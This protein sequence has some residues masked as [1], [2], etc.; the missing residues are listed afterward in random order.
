MQEHTYFRSIKQR[1]HGTRRTSDPSTGQKSEWD[2]SLGTDPPHGFEANTSKE[3]QYGDRA[4]L[5]TSH[6]RSGPNGTAYLS[7][8]KINTF[9]LQK[10]PWVWYPPCCCPGGHSCPSC[11]GHRWDSRGEGSSDRM[12]DGLQK[13]TPVLG[14]RTSATC[15]TMLSLLVNQATQLFLLI[16]SNDP[17]FLCS[18]D[19]STAHDG[20]VM[21]AAPSRPPAPC[22]CSY[23]LPSTA[24]RSDL[25]RVP[26]F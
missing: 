21:A 13:W 9:L 19:E 11:C 2:G 7:L 22:G 26:F 10:I 5:L 20:C 14:S 17:V 8:Q 6:L 1:R 24:S 23:T 25:R 4:L 3:T 18:W 12:Q 15:T 16:Y